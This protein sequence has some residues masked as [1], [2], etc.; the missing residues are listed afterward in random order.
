MRAPPDSSYARKQ[1][2]RGRTIITRILCSSAVAGWCRCY[3]YMLH[4][5]GNDDRESKK[6]NDCPPP[7]RSVHRVLLFPLIHM[8]AGLCHC[9]LCFPILRR[10]RRRCSSSLRRRRRSYNRQLPPPPHRPRALRNNYFTYTHVSYDSRALGGL[11]TFGYFYFL[12]FLLSPDIIFASHSPSQQNYIIFSLLLIPA[13][14]LYYI[15]I[16]TRL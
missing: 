15:Y 13:A 10:R 1:R 2:N 11:I 4:T 14:V 12:F 9:G 8:I 7:L 6:C 5:L 3:V 16:Y